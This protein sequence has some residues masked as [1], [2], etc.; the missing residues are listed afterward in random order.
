MEYDFSINP[1]MAL[2][3]IP[4]IPVAA[5]YFKQKSSLKTFIFGFLILFTFS[6]GT[7]EILGISKPLI[8]LVSE[9]LVIILLIFSVISNSKK[10]TF[11]IPGFYF[12]T[13]F[14]VFS[15]ISTAISNTSLSLLLLFYRDYIFI[16]L[17]FYATFNLRFTDYEIKLLLKLSLLC[18]SVQIAANFIKYLVSGSIIEPYVGSM[19]VLGGSLTI[20]FALTG[21]AYAIVMYLDS[22]NTKFLLLLIGFIAF[23]IIGGKRATVVYVPLL[24]LILLIRHQITNGIKPMILF[25]QITLFIIIFLTII[26]LSIRLMPSFNQENKVWGT[27][28]LDYALDYSERYVSTGAGAIDEIGR[29]AAP[30]YILKNTASDSFVNFYF[31]YG[32]G[33]LI[34][35]SLNPLIS[36]LGSQNELTK[37]LYGVGYGARTAFLQLFLQVG[38]FGVFLYLC[39]WYKFF[40]FAQRNLSTYDHK[41]SK[42]AYL[43]LFGFSLVFLIDFFTYSM[44]VTNI[45]SVTI[46]LCIM[47]LITKHPRI[48]CEIFTNSSKKNTPIS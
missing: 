8:R 22:K 14:T 35:S 24:Y 36:R 39:I 41:K 38:I 42:S 30:A 25:K 23:S 44:V 19:A 40:R 17:L 43:I 9:S 10:M 48:A 7:I 13:G 47:L 2:C 20:I 32:S 11:R 21:S 4:L 16:F 27:F 37:D 28:D 18:A 6:S 45:N 15:L 31:G 33:H 34:K 46:I 5:W 29:S 1:L 3:G 12:L 26:Y